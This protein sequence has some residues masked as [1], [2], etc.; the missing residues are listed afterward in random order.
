MSSGAKESRPIK[1]ASN[2][3]PLNPLLTRASQPGGS[4]KRTFGFASLRS[5]FFAGVALAAEF[6]A[7]AGVAALVVAPVL[8]AAS[9]ALPAPA[10][11][12]VAAGAA[13]PLAGAAAPAV[14][15]AA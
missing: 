2:P 12:G 7:G 14:A 10:G 8:A 13:A 1:T 3:G 15:G 5:Y 6:A 9:A 4:V 11:A